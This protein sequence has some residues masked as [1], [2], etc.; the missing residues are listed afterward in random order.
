L[1]DGSLRDLPRGVDQYLE[2]R[3][4]A[5][6]SN[7]SQSTNKGTSSAAE[8]RQLKKDVARLE[9]QLVKIDEQI[10][11]LLEEQS[12]AA[13]NAERLMEITSKLEELRLDKN[14]KEEEWLHATTALDN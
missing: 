9:K 6:L 13:F 10:S 3:V 11:A 5:L 8:Q 7:K 1:G 4:D 12:S 14:T 2:Q